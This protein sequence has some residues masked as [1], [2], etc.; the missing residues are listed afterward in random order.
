M[1]LVDIEHLTNTYLNLHK[2][3]QLY[4]PLFPSKIFFKI[5]L[6]PTF[7]RKTNLDHKKCLF[8]V[9]VLGHVLYIWLW[10][11]KDLSR[12]MLRVIQPAIRTLCLCHVT[13]IMSCYQQASRQIFNSLTRS[14]HNKVMWTLDLMHF[15]YRYFFSKYILGSNKYSIK[16]KSTE[17]EKVGLGFNKSEYYHPLLLFI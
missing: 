8:D 10:S 6:H 15:M 9:N 14:C 3:L 4:K 16:T 12:C 7:C 1:K 2:Y 11:S 17:K 13:S 5:P